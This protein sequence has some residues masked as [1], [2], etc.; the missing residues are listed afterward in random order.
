YGNA[1][2]AEQ[3]RTENLAHVLAEHLERTFGPIE[4]ALEQLAA[5]SERIGG[6]K[7][8][9]EAWQPVLAAT[10]SGLSGIGSLHVIDAEGVI[11]FST[12]PAVTGTSRRN[13]FLYGRLRG[14]PTIRLAIGPPAPSANY[15]G[16]F[17]PIGRA[18]RDR[19]GRFI[20][21]LAAT[22]QPDRLR[23]FYETIDVG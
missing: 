5:H 15:S 1:L 20:G 8:P 11:T 12:N 10:L 18:L 23:S 14:D 4:S 22:F 2:S 9:A 7:A 16:V 3:G 6:P 19:E 13:F 17:I 21:L